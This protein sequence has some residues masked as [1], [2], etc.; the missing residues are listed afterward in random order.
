MIRFLARLVHEVFRWKFYLLGVL[1]WVSPL[2]ELKSYLRPPLYRYGEIV[3]F[4]SVLPFNV[5]IA[6]LSSVR[7]VLG[8]VPLTLQNSYRNRTFISAVY[9]S[10]SSKCCTWFY[11]NAFKWWALHWSCHRGGSSVVQSRDLRV[12]TRRQ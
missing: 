6:F 12:L 3:F 11:V 5:I 2:F 4:M 9:S 7:F 10:N 1:L 8:S